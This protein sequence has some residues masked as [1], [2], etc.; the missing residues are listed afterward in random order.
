MD[1]DTGRVEAFGDGVFAIAITLPILE[2]MQG[3]SYGDFRYR[4]VKDSS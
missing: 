3:A 2:I 1:Q 4:R